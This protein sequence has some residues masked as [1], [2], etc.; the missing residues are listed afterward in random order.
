MLLLQYFYIS[1]LGGLIILYSYF[2]RP[3]VV[4]R[5]ISNMDVRLGTNKVVVL[6]HDC[7][8]LFLILKNLGRHVPLYS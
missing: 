5:G 8:E 1:C 4:V 7:K 2:G 6:T 3:A